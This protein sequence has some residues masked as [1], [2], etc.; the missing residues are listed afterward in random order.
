LVK[1]FNKV[2]LLL[3]HD[4]RPPA[5]AAEVLGVE[6]NALP[7]PAKARAAIG[8]PAKPPARRFSDLGCSFP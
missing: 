4:E 6:R 8:L 5:F 3:G 7:K 2:R 1:E